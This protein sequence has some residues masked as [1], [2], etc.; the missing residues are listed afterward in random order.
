MWRLREIWANMAQFHGEDTVEK[1]WKTRCMNVLVGDVLKLAA[2]NAYKWKFIVAI[3]SDL[4][5]W[6]L[7]V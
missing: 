7:I 3:T 4:R 6:N 2:D 5:G 1:L